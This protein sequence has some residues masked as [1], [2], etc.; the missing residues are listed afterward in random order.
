MIYPQQLSTPKLNKSTKWSNN[1]FAS[2]K[3]LIIFKYVEIINYAM[4]SIKIIAF[5]T[6]Y[7]MG[8]VSSTTLNVVFAKVYPPP[9]VEQVHFSFDIIINNET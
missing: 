8:R 5:Y 4:I 9:T 7:I 2:I 1:L 6:H 3:I